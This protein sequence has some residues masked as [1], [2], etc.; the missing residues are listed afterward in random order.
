MSACSVYHAKAAYISYTSPVF[1]KNIHPVKLCQSPFNLFL[2]NL[3]AF[4]GICTK[5]QIHRKASG[6]KKENPIRIWDDCITVS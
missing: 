6:K 4:S 3:S 2:F 5:F 1:H